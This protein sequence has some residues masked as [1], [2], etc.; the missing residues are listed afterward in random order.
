MG[1]L[2][3]SREAADIV[4]LIDDVE[5]RVTIRKRVEALSAP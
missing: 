5:M 2:S 1:R 3:N 4:R